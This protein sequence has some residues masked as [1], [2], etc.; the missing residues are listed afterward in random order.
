MPERLLVV[1][2]EPSM[3]EFLEIML[4]HDGYDVRT[5]ANGEEG[6]KAYRQA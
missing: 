1:D 4:S 3:R 6:V 2:D 5:A